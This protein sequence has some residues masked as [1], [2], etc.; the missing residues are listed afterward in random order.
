MIFSNMGKIRKIR[1]V[2][3]FVSESVKKREKGIALT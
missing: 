2:W 1:R 3:I